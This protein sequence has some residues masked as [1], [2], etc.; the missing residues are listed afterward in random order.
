MAADPLG[1]LTVFVGAPTIRHYMGEEDAPLV[2]G[3]ERFSYFEI[4]KRTGLPAGR[5]VRIISNLATEHGAKSISDLYDKSSPS[6]IAQSEFGTGVCT[7]LMLFR[8]FESE[9]LNVKAWARKGENW[10]T[11][12]GKDNFTTFHTYKKKE[13]SAERRTA[14]T[15]A[16]GPRE[17]GYRK[18]AIKAQKAA[19]R[20]RATNG[21]HG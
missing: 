17:K 19:D 15:P 14:A 2:I 5:T 21:N 18:T 10:R 6:S 16:G 7:L 8:L 12:E 20:K 1:H 3:R 9:G 11:E 13:L 4:A